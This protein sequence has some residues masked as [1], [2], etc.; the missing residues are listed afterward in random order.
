MRLP[1]R[2]SVHS[3]IP[4]RVRAFRISAVRRDLVGP[5][6]PISN[7]RPVVYDDAPPAPPSDVRHPYSLREFTGDTREYQWKIQRQQ[8][9]AYNQEFWTDVSGIFFLLLSLV[10]V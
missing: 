6:D 7:L 2:L 8:L 5:P 10:L 1:V 9:D 3:T 4:R